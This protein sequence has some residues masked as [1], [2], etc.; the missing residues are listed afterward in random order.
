[1]SRLLRYFI[2]AAVLFALYFV[3][4]RSG[5]APLLEVSTSRPGV[6]RAGTT[7]TVRAREPHRG[8]TSIRVEAL[9]GE[10]A[11]TLAV[12]EA[13]GGSPW[14][15]WRTGEV[16]AALPVELNEGTLPALTEGSLTLR[17]TAEGTG[18][19][20]RGPKRAT[21]D[22]TLLVRL[23]PPSLSLVS[24]QNY[25]AQGGSGLVIYR[26]D[27]TASEE[28][29]RDGVQA[30]EWFFPGHP[31]P[32]GDESERFALYGVPYD[33][34]DASGIRLL[35]ED[36]F[37]NRAEIAFLERFFPRPLRTDTI[38]L[39]VEFMA[40]V[41]PEI[42]AHT[43]EV[44]DQGDLLRSYLAI[45]GELR[46]R[47]AQ[48]LRALGSRSR[49]AF[50]WV[51]P[52]LQ[53]PGSQVTSSFAD[54]R[55]YRFEGK[56]VDRQDHL[57]FDLASVRAAGVPASNRGVVLLAGYLGIYG[58]TVVLDHGFGLMSLYSH[59]SAI[60]VSEGQEVEKGQTLGRTGDTGL[61]GG[62]HLHFTLLVHGLPVNPIEWWDPAWVRDR[63]VAK[64]G[65]DNAP[66]SSVAPP[67]SAHIE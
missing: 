22:L 18:A 23:T 53:L 48:A 31:L 42:L 63:I 26:V 40:K 38:R 21:E 11:V 57:G 8:L 67:P 66:R 47:N 20:F 5:P 25:A 39:S 29:A 34:D 46:A 65:R 41:V 10:R 2:A 50:L 52:F 36:A 59:L 4:L 61:A 55:T 43:A 32:G 15:F 30:G 44:S 12:H 3:F 56:D 27:A 16:D 1:M 14:A 58:N 60:E 13:S 35:A 51:G 45:N 49:A 19:V 6:G 37:G 24:R 62:D 33:L 9:Q 28:G 64:F 17:V 54:R 7:L